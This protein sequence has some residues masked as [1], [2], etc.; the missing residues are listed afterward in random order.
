MYR[1]LIVDDERI[2]REGIKYLI[3]RE[4]GDYE[5]CEAS[6]G[7]QALDIL[8]SRKVDLLMTDIRMSHMDG[9]ELSRKAREEYNDLQIV[10]FSGYSDFSFAQEA[11]QYGVLDYVLK[12]VDPERFHQVLTKA[13]EEIS[14]RQQQKAQEQKEKNFLQQYFLQSYLYSGKEEVLEQAGEIIDLNNWE[15]W[16][17]G[18]LVETERSYRW[19]MAELE[20]TARFS[21]RS[22]ML[23]RMFLVGAVETAGLL[24]VIWAVQPRFSYSFGR[25]F[26]YMMVPY[27][28]A[29]LLGSLYERKHRTDNGWGSIVIC[30]LPSAFFAAAPYCLSSLYEERFTV[31]WVVAFVLLIISLGSSVRRWITKMEEP[32]WSL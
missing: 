4:K 24:V 9:L 3:G 32:A 26:L 18:I 15:Q 8:H 17:C 28:S 27:L 13:Q 1:I 30:L 14:R 10:I 7:K 11:I 6:N 2:E 19:K 21:L 20:Y 5:I 25:V 12:P 29:S 23:A 31:V 16:H 22:V